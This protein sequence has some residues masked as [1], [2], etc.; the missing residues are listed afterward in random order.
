MSDWYILQVY[1]GFEEQVSSDIKDSLRGAGLLDS[2]HDIV[3][4]LKDVSQIRYGKKSSIKRKVIS[5]YVFLCVDMSEEIFR[6]L[7]GISRVSG[8]VGSSNNS[9][10]PYP[11]LPS[12]LDSLLQYDE[13]NIN[14]KLEHS[15]AVGEVVN[16]VQGPFLSFNGTIDEVDE[17]RSRLK[18]FVS[19]F[20]RLTSVEL[21]YIQVEKLS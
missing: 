19:I 18:L 6:L 21:D 1:S 7:R 4:P 5:G 17:V 9:G 2:L 14:D 16:I 11:V 15:F 13:Q 10:I 20:G 3:V 8:F 12:E